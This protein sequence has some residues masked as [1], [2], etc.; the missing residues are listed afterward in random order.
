MLPG[1]R[2][3]LYLLLIPASQALQKLHGQFLIQRILTI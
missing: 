1:L 2:E 3:R